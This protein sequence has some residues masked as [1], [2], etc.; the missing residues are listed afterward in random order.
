MARATETDIAPFSREAQEWFADYLIRSASILG[1]ILGCF[2]IY[3]WYIGV[4]PGNQAALSFLLLPF[5]LVPRFSHRLSL[6]TKSVGLLSVLSVSSAVTF[7]GSGLVG[8]GP[9]VSAL[10]A[11]TALVFY[12]NRVFLGLLA[13]MVLAVGLSGFAHLNGL[14]TKLDLSLPV[15]VVGKTGTVALVMILF[16]FGMRGASRLA[17]EQRELARLKT[18]EVERALKELRHFIQSANAPI[19]GVDKEGRVN[20]WNAM[21]AKI[22]GY[23][24]EEALGN[25]L[26][27]IYIAAEHMQS[28][29]EVLELGLAGRNTANYE[30]PLYSKSGERIEIL[31][32]ATTRRDSDGTIVGVLGVG[33][34]ITVFREQERRLRQAH[35]V[36]SVGHLAGGIAH[37]FNNLL[38]VIRG[39]VDIAISS[40]DGS[41]EGSFL[42]ECLGDVVTASADATKLTKQ[43]LFASSQQALVQETVNLG[44]LFSASL[45]ESSPRS[46]DSRV[47]SL[48]IDELDLAVVV[49][50]AQ[51]EGAIFN[52]IENAKDSTGSEGRISVRVSIQQLTGDLESEYS[53]QAGEYIVITV[54][55]DGCGIEENVLPKVTDPFF[56]TKEV[57]EGVGLG[58]SVVHGFVKKIGGELRLQSEPGMGTR[59]DMV[60]PLIRGQA[61]AHASGIETERADFPPQTGTALVVE[62][63]GRL[64]KLAA[65]HL[66]S[67][68]FIVIEAGNAE[69]ALT[70]LSEQGGEIN[71]LFSDIRMP[72]RLTGR[73]LAEE[74]S[75]LYPAVRTLLTTGYEDETGQLSDANPT[76]ARNFPLLRKPYSRSELVDA[77]IALDG[78]EE[79]SVESRPL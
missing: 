71:I 32:N 74:V 60:L 53:L 12:G 16:L 50:R 39:N 36:E 43:L 76:G 52:L 17:A 51:L 46:S 66:A 55:D 65:R 47:I 37:E 30:L 11:F 10:S 77:V 9:L 28:V 40:L 42:Q 41:E 70:V 75:S 63:E 33:Q 15:N 48:D 73:H 69:E 44:S 6:R 57:G 1:P 19:F 25:H 4:M 56:T 7:H 49:D 24:R 31:L 54:S 22:T 59:V 29:T 18:R 5:A 21:A 79:G 72:G 45:G 14:E 23:S 38:A 34:D 20:E 61:D 58:L 62:D 35:R 78:R 2:L 68:G 3:R 67:V 27:N 26:V 8:I 13:L 64:R